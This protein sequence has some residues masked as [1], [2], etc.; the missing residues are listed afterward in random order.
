MRIHSNGNVGIGTSSPDEKLSVN[1]SIQ[2][3]GSSST[4]T[5]N[6]SKLIFTR[7]L[8]DSDESDILHEFIL[9]IGQDL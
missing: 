6:E 7:D 8:A 9:V 2:I 1:G 4:T 3:K 5:T